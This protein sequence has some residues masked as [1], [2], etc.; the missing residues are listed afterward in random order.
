MAQEN[1]NKQQG[2]NQ[3]GAVKPAATPSRQDQ[4]SRSG[5]MARERDLDSTKKDSNMS[6]RSERI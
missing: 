6:D 1:F 4:G 3:G 5:D 2:Q